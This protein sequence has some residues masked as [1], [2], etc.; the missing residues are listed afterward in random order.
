MVRTLI[1]ALNEKMADVRA[2]TS[3]HDGTHTVN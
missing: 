2:E 1:S 3:T